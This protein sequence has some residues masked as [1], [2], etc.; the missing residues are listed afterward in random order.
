M[1]RK[2]CVFKVVHQAPS[3]KSS[4]AHLPEFLG[5]GQGAVPTALVRKMIETSP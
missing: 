5:V 3:I 1:T 2:K 4:G